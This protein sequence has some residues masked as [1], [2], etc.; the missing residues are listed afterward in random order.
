MLLY[1]PPCFHKFPQGTPCSLMISS[2]APLCLSLG[3]NV[4]AKETRDTIPY[5]AS[6][7]GAKIWDRKAAKI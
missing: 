4:D 3:I 5:D 6:I 2:H 1:S 7:F